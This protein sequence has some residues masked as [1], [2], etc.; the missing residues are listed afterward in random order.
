ME[1]A[2]NQDLV[3]LMHDYHKG[4]VKE[5]SMEDSKEVIRQALVD[6]NGGSTKLDMKSFRRNPALYDIIET[7][8]DKEVAEGLLQNDWF[9]EFCEQRNLAEGDSAQFVVEENSDLVVAD[10]ARGTQGI[11]RQRIGERTTITVKPTPH[12]VKVYDELTR[13][14]AGKADINVLIDKVSTAMQKAMLDDQFAAW[15]KLTSDNIGSDY[16]PVAGSYTE[17]A[18]FNLINH[19][20]AANG[21][22]PVMLLCTLAGARKIGTTAMLSDDTKKDFYNYGYPQKWNGIK[23][24][25]VPQRHKVGSNE[26]IFDDNKICVIPMNKMDKPVKQVIGGESLLIV[27]NPEDNTDLTQNITLINQ[28]GTT[29]ITGTK[30]GIYEMA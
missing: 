12:A 7:L 30:F 2:N 14:L 5:Y 15:N 6:L 4:T 18:L 29:V 20:S 26:F 11:R 16:Y 19:V 8:I 28:W 3:Q 25:A 27:D 17:E 23:V 10:V 1:F 21:G 13:I 22:D 9:T 24:V